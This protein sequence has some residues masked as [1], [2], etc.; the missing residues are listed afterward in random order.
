MRNVEAPAARHVAAIT[1]RKSMPAWES[2]PG[3]TKTMYDMA[4]KVVVPPSASRRKVE[5][6]RRDGTTCRRA[7]CNLSRPFE[8]HLVP[9]AAE[10]RKSKLEIRASGFRFSN[11]ECRLP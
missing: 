5:C 4:R 1:A 7:I 11:F 6:E 3:L 2:T 8:L 9:G 10:T